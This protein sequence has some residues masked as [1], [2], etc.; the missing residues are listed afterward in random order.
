MNVDDNWEW[1]F[2]PIPLSEAVQSGDPASY[3]FRPTLDTVVRE[4]VQNATDQR[5]TSDPVRVIFTFA[6][7]SDAGRSELLAASR[8]DDLRRGECFLSGPVTNIA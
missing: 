3:V 4:S 1:V 8:W 2:D 6:E 7:L 5:A